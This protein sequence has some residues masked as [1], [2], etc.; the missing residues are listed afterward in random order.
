PV[1]I[2]LERGQPTY[3]YSDFTGIVF[4]DINGDGYPDYIRSKEGDYSTHWSFLNNMSTGSTGWSR[5]SFQWDTPAEAYTN[6]ANGASL[7][8]LNGDGLPVIVYMKSGTNV[9]YINNGTSWFN[10]T[11][12]PWKNTFGYGDLS[13]GSTQFADINGDGLADLIVDDGTTRKTLINTGN[14]WQVD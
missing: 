10:D 5:T 7:V 8:D 13:N 14:A 9:V 2:I 4:E 3:G 1:P 6:L 11:A 12:S